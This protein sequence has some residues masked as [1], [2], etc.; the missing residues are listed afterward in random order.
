V[1]LQ[2]LLI[3]D[4]GVG[5]SCLLLRFAVSD[6]RLGTLRSPL[7]CCDFMLLQCSPHA[8]SDLLS[9]L[10]RRTTHTQRVTSVPLEWTLWVTLACTSFC[11]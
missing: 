8:T 2:L 3:G 5:K 10:F 6:N 4:S 7:P 11:L 1:P 9:F